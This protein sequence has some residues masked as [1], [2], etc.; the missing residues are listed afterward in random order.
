MILYYQ[1][2]L[3]LKYFLLIVMLITINIIIFRNYVQILV[4]IYWWCNELSLSS[5]SECSVVS[6]LFSFNLLLSKLI[7]MLCIDRIVFSIITDNYSWK[8]SSEFR[9]TGTHK[10]QNISSLFM[11]KQHPGGVIHVRIV[12]TI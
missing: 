10:Y 7:S 8:I 4:N 9:R 11:S 5:V 12:I 3:L 2:V 6:F 1:K